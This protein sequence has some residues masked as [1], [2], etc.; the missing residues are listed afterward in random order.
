MYNPQREGSHS[1]TIRNHP[2]TDILGKTASAHSQGLDM[3]RN[4]CNNPS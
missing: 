4:Q 1:A 3:S 2:L